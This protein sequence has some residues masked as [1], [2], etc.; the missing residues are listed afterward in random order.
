M[1][2]ILFVCTGNTCRSPMAELLLKSKFKSAGI[3]D[4]RVKSAGISATDGEKMSKNSAKALKSVGIK[5]YSF[6]S[7]RLTREMLK[8]SDMVICMTKSHK[9]ALSGFDRVYT[10]GEL[11]GLSD[12]PDP[13]GGD[14]TTYIIAMQRIN[15]ACDVILN[16]ILKAKGEKI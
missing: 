3:N 2:R 13:Y 11:T 4:I 16:K 12:V 9:A 6:R 7:K 8:K 1:K 14:E 5:P 10:L 15:D